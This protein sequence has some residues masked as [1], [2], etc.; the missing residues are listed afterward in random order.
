MAGANIILTNI[1]SPPLLIDDVVSIQ[2]MSMGFIIWVLSPVI[3]SGI[4]PSVCK[5]LREG[6]RRYKDMIQMMNPPIS[7]SSVLHSHFHGLRARAEYHFFMHEPGQDHEKGKESESE[8]TK[9]L[10]TSM[11]WAP[12]PREGQDEVNPRDLLFPWS[13]WDVLTHS[14]LTLH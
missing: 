12:K 11:S 5:L 4:S 7:L 8:T 10:T 13:L 6:H 14:V 1:G 3:F 9:I 2:Q